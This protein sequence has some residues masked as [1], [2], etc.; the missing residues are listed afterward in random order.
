MQVRIVVTRYEAGYTLPAHITT[1]AQ[2]AV[3]TYFAG[4]RMGS[5]LAQ[6]D[7]LGA[8][9]AVSGIGRATV[10]YRKQANPGTDPDSDTWGA[11][12]STDTVPDPADRFVL[13]GTVGVT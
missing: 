4:L 3:T 2:A 7:L 12:V 10:E 1:P 5:A 13:H 8:V 9:T 6:N 11:W